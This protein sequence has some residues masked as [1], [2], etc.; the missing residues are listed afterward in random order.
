M[1]QMINVFFSVFFAFMW[2]SNMSFG[3][4]HEKNGMVTYENSVASQIGINILKKGENILST[5]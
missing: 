4:T 3:Q 1:G 5:F 2:L